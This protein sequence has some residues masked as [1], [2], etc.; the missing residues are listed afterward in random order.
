MGRPKSLS[1]AQ[2]LPI[3]MPIMHD[4]PSIDEDYDDE[5]DEVKHFNIFMTN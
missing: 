4:R 1:I 3:S 5:D 2:S